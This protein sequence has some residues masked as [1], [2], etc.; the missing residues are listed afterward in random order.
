MMS[1]DSN[2]EERFDITEL[3]VRKQNFVHLYLTGKYSMTK[4]AEMMGLAPATAW[5]Y[6]R[7]PAVQE[8]IA[9]LQEQNHKMVEMGLK[10]MTN[11]AMERLTELMDSPIDGVALQAVNT[12]LDR[13][14]FKAV[15]KKEVEINQTFTFEQKMNQLIEDTIYDVEI[16]DEEDE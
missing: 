5:K 1:K 8:A 12:L 4:I 2:K 15:Q 13:T 11:K 14:G 6:M 16:V 7:D 3:H 9:D 10:S